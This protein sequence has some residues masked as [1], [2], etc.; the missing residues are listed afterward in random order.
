MI[1]E[2]RTAPAS[3]KRTCFHR[4][5]IGEEGP[6]QTHVCPALCIQ[7]AAPDEEAKGRELGSVDCL[8]R[9]STSWRQG[10]LSRSSSRR[11]QGTED[12]P[13]RGS[14]GNGVQMTLVDCGGQ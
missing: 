6:T 10:T 2:V 9:G 5:I 8:A 4:T 11:L 1:G 13:R 12:T 14:T 3:R 7:P